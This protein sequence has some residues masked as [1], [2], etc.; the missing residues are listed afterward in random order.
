[1]KIRLGFVSNS[2]SSSFVIKRKST[3]EVLVDGSISQDDEGQTEE[4][5]MELIKKLGFDI[6]DFI[7]DQS[8]E[9]W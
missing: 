5:V 6:N 2:S 4:V 9:G 3:N 7:I 1:M 8:E